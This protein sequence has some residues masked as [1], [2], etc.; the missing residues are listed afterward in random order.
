MKTLVILAHPTINQSRVNKAWKNRL[1]KEG[2]TIHDLYDAYPDGRIDVSAEQELLIQFDRIVFQYP[3]WW[4]STPAL[5][6]QWQDEVLTHGFAYG[7]NGTALQGKKLQLAITV[8]ST[9]EDYQ[10]GGKHKFTLSEVTRPLQM[11]ANLCGLDFEPI[12]EL[13]GTLNTTDEEIA[14]SAKQLA[15]LLK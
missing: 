11:M 2:V 5:L 1:V 13:Y 7:S 10:I 15:K 8:G 12:F 9:F 6:K 4:Y 3:L 14:E